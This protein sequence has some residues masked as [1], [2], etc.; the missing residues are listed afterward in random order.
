M[1]IETVRCHFERGWPSPCTDVTGS[2]I[3]SA[4]AGCGN[5]NDNT[6]SFRGGKTLKN[7]IDGGIVSLEGRGIPGRGSVKGKVGF[8]R[9]G[10][11]TGFGKQST[12]GKSVT[13]SIDVDPGRLAFLTSKSFSE[14]V[15]DVVYM[16]NVVDVKNEDVYNNESGT[17]LSTLVTPS[18]TLTEEY[19]GQDG[20]RK[21]G[22]LLSPPLTPVLREAERL[23][24]LCR[25]IFL[26]ALATPYMESYYSLSLQYMSQSEPA[27]CGITSLSMA[28]NAL[29]VDPLTKWKGCW[30]WF[31]ENV[32]EV[33]FVCGDEEE[34]DEVGGEKKDGDDEMKGGVPKK[35]WGFE[36][37]KDRGITLMEFEAI[38]RCNGLDGKVVRADMTT[39]EQF[40]ADILRAC[41]SPNEVMIVSYSR[42]TLKQTGTGHFS[43]IG[44][45]SEVEDKV[46]VFDVARFKYPAYWV[47]FDLLWESMHPLDES[48][49]LP[50]GYAVLSKASRGLVHS[51]MGRMG[52]NNVSWTRIVTNIVQGTQVPKS[53]SELISPMD[54]ETSNGDVYATLENIVA[55]VSDETV[56]ELAK[57]KL[58]SGH[59]DSGWVEKLKLKESSPDSA[60]QILRKDIETS[61][62]FTIISDSI[63][64]RGTHCGRKRPRSRS[65]NCTCGSGSRKSTG[66]G[67]R[68]SSNHGT[69][70]GSKQGSGC[71]GGGGNSNRWNYENR[72]SRDRWS[73]GGGVNGNGC[74]AN[75]SINE[76][77]LDIHGVFEADDASC[78]SGD[79]SVEGSNCGGIG[80]L[81]AGGFEVRL[82][83]A[84]GLLGG[85]SE[86]TLKEMMMVR[87]QVE[88]VMK[89]IFATES[90]NSV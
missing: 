15:I 36:E 14:P 39:R 48:T 25:R 35:R 50:R 45:Y 4:V 85:F 41:Q 86:D 55:K 65:R 22:G 9:R 89:V 51:V 29:E 71:A 31:T 30:R 83:W 7:K 82:G 1:P 24:R 88:P 19:L 26:Q 54:K 84:K 87:S 47:S 5:C 27:Y 34:E 78:G 63:H 76:G 72:R 74:C 60:I 44:G 16:D 70:N 20:I 79:D 32:L 49:G 77:D 12:S 75:V 42:G 43:P 23:E 56:V 11:E 81:T 2:G 67:P 3:S 6:S 64:R 66:R 62:L 68:C 18:S 57:G 52:E 58:F 33:G 13:V 61:R 10:V 80:R 21:M 28:L 69:N 59:F 37:I 53:D 17:Q 8:G 90:R 38:A 40:K 46:L 73:G